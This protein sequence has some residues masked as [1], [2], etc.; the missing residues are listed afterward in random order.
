MRRRGCVD[1]LATMVQS[2][3]CHPASASAQSL[4]VAHADWLRPDWPAPTHVHALCTTRA[5]GCSTGAYASMNLGLH[6]GDDLQAVEANRARLVAALQDITP[7]ARPVFLDQV[8]GSTAVP[9]GADVSD[10]LRADAALASESGLACT[11]MVAD[12]MPVLFTDRLGRSV[13]AAHAGWRGLAGGVLESVL[14]SFRAFPLAMP[15][16]TAMESEAIDASAVLVWLGPCIGPK[17]FEVGE[18]VR[19]AFCAADGESEQHFVPQG[20]GKFLA[21]LSALARQ[22]LAAQGVVQ[23]YGNDGSNAWCTFS[24]PLRFYSHRRDG[25][26]GGE[27]GRMA[28]CI[29]LG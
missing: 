25:A 21:N 28:A 8:H 16:N 12:C 23:V 29:W 22:R 15:A 19:A 9:L 14:E 26:V 27:T 4:S 11:I 10:G 24:Q 1:T 18:E 20:R 7:G 6:V 2:M 13:A 5:G 3:H 17:A